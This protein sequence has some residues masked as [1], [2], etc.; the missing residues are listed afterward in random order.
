VEPIEDPAASQLTAVDG[1]LK[2][3]SVVADH[4]H[5]FSGR[6]ALSAEKL[7]E[8]RCSRGDFLVHIGV[9]LWGT[10]CER[11]SP[12]DD[13]DVA[14][15]ASLGVSMPQPRRVDAHRGD[16]TGF[17]N[18]DVCNGLEQRRDVTLDVS[19][20]LFPDSVNPIP[21]VAE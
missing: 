2:F 16:M 6:H 10:V 4:G 8:S 17:A 18:L 13:V 9:Q 20:E 14:A 5:A 21:A 7:I 3:T 1:F 11:R 12:G 15:R 19:V